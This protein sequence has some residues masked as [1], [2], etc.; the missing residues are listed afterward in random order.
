MD[1]NWDVREQGEYPV[2]TGVHSFVP[3]VGEW[4]ILKEKEYHVT[5]IRY[6]MDNNS[7]KIHV[8]AYKNL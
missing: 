1:F 8:D 4:L 6:D 7:V 5:C 2:Y 3:R